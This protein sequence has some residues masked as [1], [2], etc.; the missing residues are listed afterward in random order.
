MLGQPASLSE[1][2][3]TPSEFQGTT[4][5]PMPSGSGYALL[6]SVSTELDRSGLGAGFAQAQDY[7]DDDP[8]AAQPPQPTGGLRITLVASGSESGFVREPED[9]EEDC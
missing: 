9:D 5:G 6:S 4:E 1:L 8:E 7:R 3:F 2:L